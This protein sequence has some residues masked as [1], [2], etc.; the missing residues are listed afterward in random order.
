MR[1]S[2]GR[3]IPTG[4]WSSRQREK[5]E[6]LIE[7]LLAPVGDQSRE[8]AFRMNVTLCRHRGL[9]DHEE[10]NLPSAFH[11]F[12]ANDTAGASIELLWAEGVTGEAIQPCEHPSREPIA[13]TDDPDLWLP[14]PC[15]ACGPC[16]ARE[17]ARC[18]T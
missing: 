16:R 7:R 2:E 11:A 1:D 14:V 5:A 12:R 13:G 4:R 9:T 10:A 6:R 8:V 17:R 15:E 3:I 18:A